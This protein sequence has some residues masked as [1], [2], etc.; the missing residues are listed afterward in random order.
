MCVVASARSTC[1]TQ[2][3]ASPPQQ[4]NTKK[5]IKVWDAASGKLRRDLPYQADE[6]FMMHDDAVLALSVS[7]DGELLASGVLRSVC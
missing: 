7:R 2:N 3:T 1:H 4:K 6:T 5:Q